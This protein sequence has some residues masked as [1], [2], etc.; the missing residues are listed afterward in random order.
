ML[1][2]AQLYKEQLD[3]KNI[4]SWYKQEN[5]YWHGGTAEYAIDLP[6]NNGN[7]HCFVSVDKNDNVIGWISYNVDWVSMSSDGWGIISFEKGNMEF[8][9][10]LYQAICDCFEVY[11]LNRISWNCY[12]DN[13]AIR[14][15][16]NFIK[17]HGGRE[18]AYFR[19]YIKLRDGKLHD[20]VSFEIL[21]SEFQGQSRKKEKRTNADC[22]RS[23]SDEELAMNMMC[24]NE[25]GLGEIECDKSDNCNCYACILK[26]L[27]S[28]VEE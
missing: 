20:S 5:I 7:C 27:Q 13:P 9:K 17:K 14:G 22:I 2:P 3:K 8:V 28:E 19:Q 6:D 4:E 16:R 10:D 25:N 1:R 11:H 26:W 12:A 18:C 23:M 21:A 15:Y 24:P